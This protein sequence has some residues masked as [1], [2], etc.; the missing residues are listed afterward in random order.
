MPERNGDILE[1]NYIRFMRFILISVFLVFTRASHAQTCE[2]LT[3]DGVWLDPFN[4]QQINVLCSNESWDEIYSYPSWLMRDLEGNVIA[5]EQVEYF[6]ISGASF[7]R[8]VPTNPWPDN[9]DSMPVTMELW[10]GFGEAL[11]CSFEWEFVPRE[12]EWTG[13]GD[14]GCFPVRVVAYSNEQDGCSLALSL[15]NGAGENVWSEVLEINESTEFVAQSDSLCLSQFECYDLQAVSS[16]TSYINMQL[17]DPA[18]GMAWNLQHW[19]Y[20]SLFGEVLS[21]DTTFTLDLYGGN[22]SEAQT[23][24]GSEVPRTLLHPNPVGVGGRF[25]VPFEI[26]DEMTLWDGVGHRIAL[27]QSAELMAPSVAG[28]YYVVVKSVR[29][30]EFYTLIVR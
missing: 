28:V 8:M 4:N 11:A 18:E 5:E 23:I 7:H 22:C 6:G 14:Q 9:A 10:T 20:Y 2:L 26:G 17:V 24:S 21:L 29:N 12:L 19:S 30:T 15:E 13:T 16:P 1:I 27:D 3:L 25:R